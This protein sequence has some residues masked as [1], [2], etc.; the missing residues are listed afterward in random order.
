MTRILAITGASGY[1]GRHLITFL[2]STMK[3]M[4]S[5]FVAIDIKHIEY[6]E[7]IPITFYKQDIRDDFSGILNNH[8]VTDLVHMAWTLTPTHNINQAYSVDIEG[9]KNT[10]TMA[11][12]AG[13]KYFLHTSSTLAYGAYQD[14]PY[15]LYETHPLRGNPNFHYPYHKAL[16]EALIDDF[17]RNHPELIIGRIRPSAILSYE[18]TNY[19]A[20]IIRGGW[21]TFFLMPYP[22]K[23]TPI[24]FLHLWDA[25]EG[26]RLV[27]SKRL[28][29]IYN[30]A[31][32]SDYK[33]GDIPSLLNGR[34]LRVPYRVL[35]MILWIQWK[36]HI[37]QA[38]PEYLDFLAYPFVASN[39][40][41]QKEG[42]TPQFTTKDT[43]LTLKYGDPK[44]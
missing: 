39:I 44:K 41:L 18:L 14:N 32:N 24:Q 38:P 10:L 7:E 8:G 20:E 37:S 15:P 17:E 27:L 40:K 12:K 21:R 3:D 11:L 19:I 13:V 43:L 35:K 5:E 9:T 22:E 34:G 31:P 33:I 28:S 2:H 36:L 29:G 6:P 16:A 30:L 42:F 23:N 25:L 26:F 1:L 4:I